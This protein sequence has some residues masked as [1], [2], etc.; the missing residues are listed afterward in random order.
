MVTTPADIAVLSAA[1]ATPYDAE[2]RVDPERIGMLVDDYVARGVEGLYC[3]GSSG[4]G[5]LLTADERVEVVRAASAAAAGRVPVIAHVGALSTREAVD[6][7]VRSQDAGAVAVSMV[8][9]I[10]Y[11]YGP[12]AIAEHYR[13]VMD[14][15]DVPMILYNIPQ[16]TGTEFDPDSAADLLEDE[17]VIGVKQ[18]AHNMFHL[19]RMRAA[20]PDKAYIGGFD[21]VFV[22]AVA[23]GAR[24]AIGTTIG[25]QVELFLAAREMLERGDLAGAQRVQSRIGEVVAELVDIDVFPAAKELSGLPFG[26]LGD[27]RRPFRPLSDEQR[28]RVARL[29]DVVAEHI[30]TTRAERA[31]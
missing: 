23:A 11:R 25:F 9:P 17:R 21:E 26:G 18:T 27:C 28:S 7:A 16:F 8:P 24:G 22:A 31:R 5:L 19:E 20:F 30:E 6:L 29:A 13:T 14:A 3:C 15:V 4:E 10:Y 1:L 2:G 12:E